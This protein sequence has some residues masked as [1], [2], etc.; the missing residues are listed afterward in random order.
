MNW[1]L[2]LTIICLLVGCTKLRMSNGSKLYRCETC[3]GM[4]RKLMNKLE[5]LFL[6]LFQK[7]KLIFSCPVLT[8]MYFHFFKLISFVTTLVWNVLCQYY[9]YVLSWIYILQQFICED[10][11]LLRNHHQNKPAPLHCPFR[12]IIRNI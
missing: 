9:L 7:T 4:T 11:P 10:F 8:I 3:P 1:R 6:T 2:N 12:R 5:S